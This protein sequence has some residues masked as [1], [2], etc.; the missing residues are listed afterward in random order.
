MASELQLNYGTIAK[1]QTY[2][3]K[4]AR[5][6]RPSSYVP[7]TVSLDVIY[8]ERD[9][10]LALEGVRYWDLMRRGLN[11]AATRIN[12]NRGEPFISNFNMAAKGLFPIPSTEII[13]ENNSLTQNPGY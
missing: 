11:Y 13:N 6:S 1:A 4:V 3:E 8:N 2:F 5:R 9:L 12:I 10:E 7:P